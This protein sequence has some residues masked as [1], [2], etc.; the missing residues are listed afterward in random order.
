MTTGIAVLAEA[1]F[2][3]KQRRVVTACGRQVRV[4]NIQANVTGP[5][6]DWARVALRA[7]EIGVWELESGAPR[8]SGAAE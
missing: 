5:I 6:D 8:V 7:V 2:P 3:Q 4:L 1:G